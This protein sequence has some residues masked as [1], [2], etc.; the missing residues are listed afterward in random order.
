[1]DAYRV[2]VNRMTSSNAAVNAPFQITYVKRHIGMSA[3]ASTY[4]INLDRWRRESTKLV[5][6]ASITSAPRVGVTIVAAPAA[7]PAISGSHCRPCGF[8]TLVRAAQAA[9]MENSVV[10]QWWLICVQSPCDITAHPIAT[11][12]EEG[13]CLDACRQAK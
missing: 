9:T 5:A 13:A 1:M 7:T 3:L 2:A 4:A 10:N 11:S 12:A 8:S 6:A